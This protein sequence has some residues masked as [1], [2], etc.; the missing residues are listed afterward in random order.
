MKSFAVLALTLTCLM[1]SAFAIHAY[2]SDDCK[3]K[4][5]SVSYTGN[6]PVGGYYEIKNGK[7][8]ALKIL[9]SDELENYDDADIKSMPQFTVINRNEGKSKKIPATK[10]DCFE[11]ETRKYEQVIMLTKLS[12]VQE[13]QLEIENNELIILKCVEKFSIPTDKCFDNN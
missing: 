10:N 9:P 13:E 8:E 12:S 3:Y 5:I 6:Y 4:K 11:T 2:R 1:N 7:K